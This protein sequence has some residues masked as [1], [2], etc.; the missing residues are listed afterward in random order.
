VE[1][2]IYIPAINVILMICCVLLVV[3]FRTSDNLASAYGVAVCG[4]ML[5]TST[6][7]L[8]LAFLRWRWNPIVIAWLAIQFG[9]V[10]IAFLSSNLRKVPAGG[11]FPLMF[12]VILVILMYVWRSGQLQLKEV[13]YD[14]QAPVES[15]I[16]QLKQSKISYCGGTGV[17]MSAVSEGIPHVCTQFL[18][19]VPVVHKTSVFLTI[20]YRHEPFVGRAESRLIHISEGMYRMVLESGYMETTLNIDYLQEIA[21][22]NNT[23]IEF[24]TATYYLGNELVTAKK[25]INKL[26]K[27]KIELFN[28]LLQFSH[29]STA[30]SFRIPDGNLIYVGNNYIL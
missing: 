20:H 19:H 28:L 11:W 7:F 12:A 30:A 3:G 21:M 26:H 13:M 6:M 17:F 15:L 23:H 8:S 29:Q 25:T 4:D 14:E 16:D 5:L 10:D 18:Q 22:L 9:I 24:A 1:G 2:Q 27:I